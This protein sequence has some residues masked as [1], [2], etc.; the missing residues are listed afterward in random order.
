MASA[1]FSQPPTK[2]GALTADLGLEG[3]QGCL[4]RREADGGLSGHPG[5][6]GDYKIAPS[7]R[8]LRLELGVRPGQCLVGKEHDR[9]PV[10]EPARQTAE[11]R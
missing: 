2:Q 4:S 6:S 7:Q 9:H 3:Q 5:D 1:F 11:R 8:L 10:G